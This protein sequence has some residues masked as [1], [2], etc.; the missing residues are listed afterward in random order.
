[1]VA[2]CLHLYYVTILSFAVDITPPEIT[3]VNPP[4][5]TNENTTISW[6]FNEPASATCTLSSPTDTSLVI[7]EGMWQ[8]IGLMEGFYTLYVIATDTSDN[9]ASTRSVS[10]FVGKMNFIS[11][12]V[13]LT[14]HYLMMFRYFSYYMNEVDM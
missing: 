9:I 1:M 5:K 12:L 7:C 3:F 2:L 11:K 14:L 13:A 10:W 8:G 6:T 4:S